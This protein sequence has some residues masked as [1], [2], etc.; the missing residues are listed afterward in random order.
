MIL[1][2]ILIFQENFHVDVQPNERHVDKTHT[3]GRP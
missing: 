3:Q 2:R 1:L